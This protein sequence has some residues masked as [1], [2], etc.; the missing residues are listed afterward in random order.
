MTDE[1]DLGTIEADPDEPETSIAE[2]DI[3]E[4]EADDER[5]V[6]VGTDPDGA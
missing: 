5:D 4:G 6:G 1:R 3:D 2:D